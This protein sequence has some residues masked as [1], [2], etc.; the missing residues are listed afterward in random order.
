MTP[1]VQTAPEYLAQHVYVV[2]E[3]PARHTHINTLTHTH[4][5]THMH[6]HTHTQCLWS[7][8]SLGEG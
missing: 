6:S 5:H 7:L 1:T 8:Q 4:T 3:L 2:L